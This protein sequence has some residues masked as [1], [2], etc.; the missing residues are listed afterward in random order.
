VTGLV[1]HQRIIIF[2]D[3]MLKFFGLA[4]MAVVATLTLTACG[5]EAKDT[6]PDQPVTKRR[7]IFKQF[8]RTLEPIGLVARGRETYNPREVNLS[9]LELQKLATQPWPL[10][11]ADSNY[12]PTHAKPAVWEQAADFKAAQQNF[13]GAVGEL[14]KAAQLG[15]LDAVKASVNAV[16]KS[17][18]SCHTQFRNDSAS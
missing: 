17:C 14:V 15:D 11:T 10:F 13:Q 3:D 6:H 16:E 1:W 2:Q 12:P 7:A 18:K 8:T 5:G 9:A 4:S